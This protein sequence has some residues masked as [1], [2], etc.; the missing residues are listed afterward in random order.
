[1]R[2]PHIV[3]GTV[4][5]LLVTAA[6]TGPEPAG[7][8]APAEGR[9]EVLVFSKTA[10][11]RHD[12]IPAG[13]EAVRELGAANGF[14]VTA[15]EDATRFTTADLAKYQ[16]VVFLNTTGDVLDPARQ[17]A[18]EGYVRAGGGFVG[19]HA[20]ADTEEDWPFYGELVGARFARH[21]AVQR[22]TIRVEDRS[23]PATAHL[24]PTWVRTDEWYDYRTSAR[25][26]AHVLASLDES[27]YAGGAMGADHPHAWYQAY[28]GGRSFYT[29]GGHTPASYA[30]P[31]F[32]A[33]L[34]GGIRYAAGR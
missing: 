24:G 18:F 6:C 16:A 15:T 19:V 21:P 31:A 25:S 29:G 32:R 7:E 9:Y 11:F 10:G 33:H 4:T 17:A 34:L 13:I 27:S 5:A 23:H 2:A 20:A 30:E 22:A 3:L 8:D 28:A 1:M 12:S 14:T 26:T